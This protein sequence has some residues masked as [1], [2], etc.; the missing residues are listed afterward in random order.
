MLLTDRVCF[1]DT[2]LYWLSVSSGVKITQ[3]GFQFLDAPVRMRD[4]SY[5]C[6]RVLGA[7]CQHGLNYSFFRCTQSPTTMLGDAP[8]P[9]ETLWAAEA[10]G[11]NK[12]PSLDHFDI[13]TCD[14]VHGASV[15]WSDGEVSVRYDQDM[16]YWVNLVAM[17][18]MIWLI[19]NLGESIALILE[20]KEADSH[21]HNTVM[22]SV[23]LLAVIISSTPPNGLWVTDHD[24]AL[25][26]SVVGYI[27]L[28]SLHHLRNPNT[29]NVII[30]CM[31]LLTARCYQTFETPYAS[32]FMTFISTRF[33][34]KAYFSAWGK[35]PLTAVRVFFLCADTAVVCMLHFF[36]FVPSFKEPIQAQL[37]LAG[38]LFASWALGRFIAGY[39]RSKPKQAD[40]ICTNSSS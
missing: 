3:R 6:P 9:F 34:Q 24:T 17:V 40:Q 19:V 25:Y 37:Y 23:L 12:Y 30:G 5:A 38:I 2:A 11:C 13:T 4:P 18:I 32:S 1:D 15:L 27:G 36:A 39:V 31:M 28:Y 29:I 35:T 26:W 21:H 20:M 14:L 16:S 8:P 7:L 33:V 10:P 22:L